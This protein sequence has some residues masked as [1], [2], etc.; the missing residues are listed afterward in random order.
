ME[1]IRPVVGLARAVEFVRTRGSVI[2]RARMAA[3]LRGE[4]PD[5]TALAQIA[6]LQK[7]DGGFG[8]WLRDFSS[9][10]DTVY[11]LTWLDDL[12]VRTGPSVDHAF[13]YLVERQLPDGGWDE[14]DQVRSVEHPPFLEPGKDSTRVWLSAYCAHWFV[15]F[16]RAEPPAA[17]ACPVR[18][19]E[20]KALQGNLL[21]GGQ[22]RA[23]WDAL[24][25]FNYHPGPDSDLFRRTLAAVERGYEP[26]KWE[27]NYLAWLGCCLRDAGLPL[28]HP[29]VQRCLEDLVA[30]QRPDG[31]WDSEDGEAHSAD[32]TIQVLRV[33][34]HY[35]LV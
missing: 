5:R 24:V 1:G 16:G 22:L 28:T 33:L 20:A 26:A 15:R 25:L 35:G 14:V 6:S 18:Y 7:R 13:S 32:S 31:S 34:N 17:K 3:I 2:E 30:K 11:V 23:T 10:C 8:Y 4:M 29:L 12:G 21:A 9:V 27:G 19:L